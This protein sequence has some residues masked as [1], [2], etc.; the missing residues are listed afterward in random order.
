MKGL[1][2]LLSLFTVLFIPY[3][4][5]AAYVGCSSSGSVSVGNTINVSFTSSPYGDDVYW[6]GNINYD[7]SK[8]RLVS[9][10]VK[11]WIEGKS[12]ANYTFKAI[13]SGSAYVK[14]SDLNMAQGD[15]TV[16]EN[17]TSSTCSINVSN[18]ST[19]S[20]S[21]SNSSSNNGGETTS[22]KSSNNKLTSLTVKAVNLSPKFSKD[23]LSYSGTVP[24]SVTSI[25]INATKEDSDASLYRKDEK[26]LVE[27][28]NK[29]NIVVTAPNGNSRTYSV[30]I[31]RQEADPIIVKIGKKEYTVQ[32]KLPEDFN[33][34]AGFKESTTSIDGKEVLALKNE[35]ETLTLVLLTEEGKEPKLFVYDENALTYIPF[36]LLQNNTLTLVALD[37]VKKIKGFKIKTIKINDNKIKALISETNDDFI[38]V[39]ALDIDKGKKGY[40]IYNKDSNSFI[41]YDK[42]IYSP[43]EKKST[44]KKMSLLTALKRS[45]NGLTYFIAVSVAAVLF[46]IA[47]LISLIKN[48]R[49]K[50]KLFA[51]NIEE[52]ETEIENE[53]I[54]DNN[55]LTEIDQEELNKH[56]EN[57]EINNPTEEQTIDNISTKDLVDKIE[58]SELEKLVDEDSTEDGFTFLLEPETKRKKK[59]KK[60]KKDL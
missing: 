55:T 21:N 24:N 59:K 26:E 2:K 41:K 45:K 25:S 3:A 7:S 20:N 47:T 31:T 19:S 28:A 52:V 29:F 57:M 15:S 36:N 56:I 38:L 51:G 13:A 4:V 11:P 34:P 8:L 33:I 48:R 16:I 27:G 50:K 30:L 5:N 18:S 23:T 9:G 54:E 32:T 37:T 35:N 1:L 43:F 44:N 40:Y 10:D 53:P 6:Q 42:K 17:G 22:N 46:F 14:V 60:K 39:Y 12:S 49:L 58:T